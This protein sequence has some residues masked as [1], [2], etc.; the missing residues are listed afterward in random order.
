MQRA[1]YMHWSM[2]FYIGDLSMMNVGAP[3]AIPHRDQGTTTSV[4]GSTVVTVPR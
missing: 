1:G 2:P 3:E 4:Q